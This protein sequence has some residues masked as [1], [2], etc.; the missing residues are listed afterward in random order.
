MF[1]DTSHARSIWDDIPQKWVGRHPTWDTVVQLICQDEMTF[2]IGPDSATRTE[3]VE[4]EY[5]VSIDENMPRALLSVKQWPQLDQIRYSLVPARMKE[6]RFWTNFF[7]K[8][9]E[10]GKCESL[11]EVGDL[12][13]KLNTSSTHPQESVFHTLLKPLFEEEHAWL[14][15]QQNEGKIKEEL[16]TSQEGLS[17]FLSAQADYTGHPTGNKELLE[18]LLE[19]CKYHKQRITILIGEIGAHSPLHGQIYCDRL[20]A[21]NEELRAAI[22]RFQSL[23]GTPRGNEDC[24]SSSLPWEEDALCHY[25]Q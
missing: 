20:L 3:G 22:K 15:W 2:L 11:T 10:V 12:M 21:L 16:E 23:P 13:K 14:W 7:W 6:P 18:S 17:L 1:A 25:L 5:N 19:S 9:R 8:C 24:F 4:Y